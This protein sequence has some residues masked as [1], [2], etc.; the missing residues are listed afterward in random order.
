MLY[1]LDKFLDKLKL[2]LRR[3]G[4][5]IDTNPFVM[6]IG[7]RNNAINQSNYVRIIQTNNDPEGTSSESEDSASD[8]ESE[9]DSSSSQSETT[10]SEYE[11]DQV[12]R[13]RRRQIVIAGQSL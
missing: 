11:S 2:V 8:S 12:P 10:N 6:N 5:E 13:R 1:L 3:N 9:T 4:I 7:V